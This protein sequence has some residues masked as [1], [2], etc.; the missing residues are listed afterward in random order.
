MSRV[1]RSVVLSFA[2]LSA[3]AAACS[4]TDLESTFRSAEVDGGSGGNGGSGVTPNE[5]IFVPSSNQDAGSILPP[6]APGDSR[7]QC[8]DAA[9]YDAC[10]TCCEDLYPEGKNTFYEAINQCLCQPSKC[11]SADLC[12][13]SEQCLG[14]LNGTKISKTCATCA[15]TTAAD[16]KNASLNPPYSNAVADVDAGAGVSGE[17]GIKSCSAWGQSACNANPKCQAWAECR[18]VAKCSSKPKPKK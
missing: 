10:S 7:R 11:A 17:K 1:K 3:L 16:S 18:V 5:D 12:G 15:A 8:F 2:A 14:M 4:S 9:T 13:T 6:P